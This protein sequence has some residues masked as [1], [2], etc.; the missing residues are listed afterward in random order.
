MKVNAFTSLLRL[1]S[2]SEFTCVCGGGG[3]NS[4]M[5]LMRFK[6]T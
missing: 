3:Q 1:K 4:K 2:G 5:L 6:V